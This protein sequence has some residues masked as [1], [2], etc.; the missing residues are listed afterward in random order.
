MDQ[1]LVLV[2]R[3]AKQHV[4]FFL[5]WVL[6]LLILQVQLLFDLRDRYCW[7]GFRPR[8]QVQPYVAEESVWVIV[9][10]LLAHQLSG[11]F[12]CVLVVADIDGS[13]Y[14]QEIN[15][16]TMVLRHDISE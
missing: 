4:F 14:E 15:Q 1:T 5:L 7:H 16:V 11:H 8:D 6:H 13:V 3:D 10:H 2:L 9:A 12:V